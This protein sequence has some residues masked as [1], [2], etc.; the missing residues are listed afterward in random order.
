MGAAHVVLDHEMNGKT[1]AD[2]I[3]D[4]YENT[5]GLKDMQRASRGLGTPDACSKIVDIAINL[6]K[7][8]RTK[9]K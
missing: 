2:H 3:R 5:S 4:L 8:S 6:F 7:N 1:L 9:R